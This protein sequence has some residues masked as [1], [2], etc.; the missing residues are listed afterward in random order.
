M[1]LSRVVC[2][3]LL[4]AWVAA[5]A[6]E[7]QVALKTQVRP[8]ERP[9]LTVSAPVDIARVRVELARADGSPLVLTHGA[10]PANRAAAIALPPGKGSYQGKLIA[11]FRDGNRATYDLHFDVTVA[12]DM[13]I[14][15]ARDHLDLDAHT[16]E[17]TLTRAAAHAELRVVGDDG[18]EL[19]RATADYHGERAGT[20]LPIQWTPTR[21][22]NV[23]ALDLRATSS[24]GV[25]AGVHLVPWSVRIPHEEVVFETGKSEIRPSEEAKLD[26]SYQR[27]VD[28]VAE[29]RKAEPSLPVRLFI[30][31]H[32]D[33]VGGAA[34]NRK[35]SLARARAIGAWF[36]DRGLP[37]PIAFAGFGEDALKV[38][39]ADNTDEAANRRADY[40]VGVE[41]PLVARGVRAPWYKLQ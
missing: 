25:A 8:G 9:S 13:K 7:V 6:Q 27:I 11:E 29:V 34:D 4:L 12:G 32:T 37:L 23:L 26:K 15:Y 20:W 24:D 35:L 33:T 14:G 31:G 10:V 28:A 1:L 41:E 2:T 40:I 36:H 22:G 38:K 3:L 17:F 19:G 16:L 21:A 30:A 18:Q 39:T 5:H